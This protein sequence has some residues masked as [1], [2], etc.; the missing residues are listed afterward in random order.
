LFTLLE[1]IQNLHAGKRDLQAGLAYVV[2]I[3][4]LVCLSKR[5]SLL[6]SSGV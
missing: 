5:R 4:R 1:N 6:Y 3:H 2:V